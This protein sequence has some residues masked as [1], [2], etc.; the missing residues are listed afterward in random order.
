[1]NIL[2]VGITEKNEQA[3]RLLE[4]A[5]KR[6]HTM[7]FTLP[8]R[9]QILV[10]PRTRKFRLQKLPKPIRKY[11]V[12][13]TWTIS[14]RRKKDWFLFLQHIYNKYGTTVIYGKY[15]DPAYKPFLTPTYDYLVQK[16]YKINFPKSAVFFNK[17]GA[18]WVIEQ[19]GLPAILK[20]NALGMMSKGRGVK[21]I[22]TEQELL[23]LVEEYKPVINRFILRQFI[24]NNGDIRV[25]IVG[26]KA[27]GA[28]YRHPKQGDFRSNI[29]Q[30]GYGEA[31][32]LKANPI[33]KKVAEKVARLMK[34][35]IAGVD[36]MLHKNTGKPYILEINHG[37]QFA[38]L[39]KYTKVNAALKIVK[40][41][42]KRR[43]ADKLNA[44]YRQL[45]FAVCSKFGSN[46]VNV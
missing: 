23:Q 16:K 31:Y 2:V 11:D 19:V 15:T 41:F 42:E 6:G 1:M 44:I 7:H 29:S 27:I 43:K 10:G 24:P 9:L 3:R 38:G 28:M 40:Y 36:V 37:P 45:K 34:A 20:I 39:E 4:E 46:V 5:Q 13:Y 8:S 32:N 14:P 22:K 26:Y 21:L 18:L 33:V 25:F 17:A 35:E 30:G 12:V